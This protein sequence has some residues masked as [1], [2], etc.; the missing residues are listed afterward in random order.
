MELKLNIYDKK[1]VVKTYTANTLSLEYGLVEDLLDVVD[2]EKM[3]DNTELGK[4]ILKILPL[5][6]PFLLNIFEGLSEDEIRHV[7]V[8]EMKDVF[9]EI[10]KYILELINGMGGNDEKN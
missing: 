10:Y 6:K 9:V 4:M 8:F 3:D 1:T 7:N 5:I 2:F